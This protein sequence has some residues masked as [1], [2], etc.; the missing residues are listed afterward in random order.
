MNA[1]TATKPSSLEQEFA[2]DVYILTPEEEEM[3]EA[4]EAELDAGLGISGAEFR[5]R[6]REC[7]DNLAKI[8]N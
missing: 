8:Y 4:A 1:I 6:T 7:L 2:D 5:R 3:I